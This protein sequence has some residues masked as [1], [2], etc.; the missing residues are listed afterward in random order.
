[1]KILFIGGTGN[2]STACTTLAHQKGN[3]VFVLNRG[4]TNIPV[5]EGVKVLRGDAYYQQSLEDAIKGHHF[6][7]VAN[8]IAY[9][10]EDVQ[11]D[12]N[13]FSGRIGQYIFISSASV[14]QKP[15]SHPVITES[16]PL[17]NPYWQYSRDKIACE[18]QLTKVYREQDFPITI[19][20]PSLTYQH[21]IPVALGGWTNFNVIERIRKGKKIIVHGDGTSLWTITHS[22]DFA[23]GFCGLLGHQQAIGHSFHITSDELLTWN[24]IYEAVAAAVGESPNI[25]HIP[26]DF[27]AKLWPD[28]LGSLLGDKA[29][30]TIFDNT[31]IKTFVPEFN[32]IIPFKKGIKTTIQWLESD[33]TRIHI[34]GNVEKKMDEV[35][36]AYEK[37]F[38]LI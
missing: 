16:T 7:V 4:K 27:I 9:T 34:N 1:M 22:E 35:V 2:I 18:D 24:Q 21:V 38:G 10:P 15:P 5:P 19:V 14:Y 36:V 30:S 23:I 17:K 8:F 37:G 25:I 13:V 28:K 3:E 29:V 20:R 6:D 11:R 31:K 26:S 32:A 33:P 12:I